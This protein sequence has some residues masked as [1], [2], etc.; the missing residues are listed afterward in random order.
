[1]SLEWNTFEI[2]GFDQLSEALPGLNTQPVQLSS[3]DLN[4]VID[5]ASGSDFH[6]ASMSLSGKVADR[7]AVSSETLSFFLAEKPMTWCGLEIPAPALVLSKSGRETRSVLEPGFQSLEYFFEKKSIAHHPI[8]EL[9][10]TVNGE[11]EQSVY[12]LDHSTWRRF[13]EH[14]EFILSVKRSLDDSL[15]RPTLS[16]TLRDFQLDLLYETLERFH[17][18]QPMRKFPQKPRYRL[19]LTALKLI[20]SLDAAGLSSA[21]VAFML[22]VTQRALEKAFRSVLCV[23]PAQYLLA[24]RLTIVRNRLQQAEGTVGEISFKYGFNDHSRFSRQY[25]RL[26]QE[27]PS[28]TLMRCR[29][30][31]S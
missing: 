5:S 24:Y 21:Q 6:I 1:M 8:T 23:S 29:A 16:N 13:R 15:N 3:G 7:A 26:F 17:N 11:P 9:L 4:L 31:A 30:L 10:S 18:E 28:Q 2:V 12:P 20:D 22:G 27:L 14:A 19:A 25:F